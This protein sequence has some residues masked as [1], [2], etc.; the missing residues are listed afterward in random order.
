MN[1]HAARGATRSRSPASASAGTRL[2]GSAF[3][4][5]FILVAIGW[6]SAPGDRPPAVAANLPTDTPQ[7]EFTATV[8]STGG[9][10][11]IT[12]LILGFLIVG[13]AV[14]GVIFYRPTPLTAFAANTRTGQRRDPDRIS[15]SKRAMPEEVAQKR[16]RPACE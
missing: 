15:Y 3:A 13:A 7:F 1:L 11:T 6:W 4:A 9:V 10:T 14:I 12:A 16:Q 8:V 2:A 5:L